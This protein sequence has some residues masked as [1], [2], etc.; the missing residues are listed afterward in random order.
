M[1]HPLAICARMPNHPPQYLKAWFWSI[2]ED[3]SSVG[4]T[5]LVS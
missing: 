4:Y 2:V 5:L 1:T 3:Y